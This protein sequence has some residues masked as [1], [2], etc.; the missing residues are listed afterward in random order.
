MGRTARH[1]VRQAKG[2]ATPGL[3][4]PHGE[5]HDDHH[6]GP[7]GVSLSANGVFHAARQ[8]TP[9]SKDQRKPW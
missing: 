9:L 8:L 6:T 5:P 7:P 2:A 4:G 3:T 1:G